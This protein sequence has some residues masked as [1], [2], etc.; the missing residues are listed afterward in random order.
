MA[1]TETRGFGFGLRLMGLLLAS[2]S[3]LWATAAL[4]Q[5]GNPASAVA[6]P[7]GAEA[8]QPP[9][10]AATPPAAAVDN[11]GIADI[12][13]TARFRKEN[14]QSTPV[15]V[16]AFTATTIQNQVITQTSQLEAYLPNV[17]FN[18]I[19]YAGQAL[20]A[21]IRGVS[22]ADLEKTFDPA[23]GVAIDGVFLGSN[24]GANFNFNDLESIEVLRGP[25]G[26]LYGRNTIGGTISVRRTRPTGEFGLKVDSRYSSFNNLETDAV[27]NLPKIADI[28]SIKLFGDR[29]YGDSETR[30]RYTGKRE[31]GQRFY[32]F[33]GSVLADFGVTTAL[34]TVEHQH[35]RSRYDSAVNL[36]LPTG[37][38]FGAGGTICDY[39]MAIGLGDTGCASQGYLKQKGENYELANTS[40]PFESYLAG[41]DSSL[42]IHSKIGSF[43]LTS[44]TGYRN[45][46]DQLFE[47]NTGTPPLSY[48]GV[49]GVGLPLFLTARD[50]NYKQF[51]QELRLQGDITDWMDIVGGAYYLHTKYSI[52]PYPYNGART[53]E[54]Y[55]AVPVF[56]ANGA[57]YFVE[58]PAQAFTAGQTLD[59]YAV[60]AESIF[61]LGSK[62]RL[63]VGGRYTTETK[64]FHLDQTLPT[65]FSAAA[66]KTFSDPTGRAILD[67]RPNPSTMLYVSWSR[68]F[69]SGGFNGRATTAAAIGPYN[70]ERVDSYEAGVKADFFGGKLRFNPTIFLANYDNKQ[71]EILRP[72]AGGIGTE[73]V[74]Q[75]AASARTKGVELEIEARPVHELTLH[76]TGGYLDAKYLKFLVPDLTNPG[77]IIDVAALHNYRDA[78]KFSADTGFDFL[79]ALS[80]TNSVDLTVDYSY[81]DKFTTSP[82]VDTS[83]LHRDTIAAHTVFDLSVAFIHKTDAGKSFRL[84]GYAHDLFHKGNRLTNVLDAGLFYF[85]A[86]T[87]QR[88]FGIQGTV[89]F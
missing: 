55:L 16:S 35:D 26:T 24:T 20:G 18:Q 32:S 57:P 21:S 22:F 42:E 46:N 60:F 72:A 78:P 80:D 34:A 44:I 84:S 53:A 13:V 47:E 74:V 52:R 5:S 4:A 14:L 7:P 3:P 70:P 89:Q 75:N 69:R 9:A 1:I 6:Q 40:I 29:R 33:G 31:P 61:K 2:T 25:Q 81:L 51:S 67:Y 87:R 17:H 49:P 88:E 27:L 12:V 76:A 10:S 73:T 19:N 58:S 77:A 43:N 15:A 8:P 86:V 11:G 71:E 45:T 23:I 64:K 54:A 68:G 65:A 38:P 62:V 39:T 36:T 59:S 85:G 63:T 28:F 66:K 30:D 83:G 79:H 48:T 37:L 56:P 50:Q 41:W 82:L